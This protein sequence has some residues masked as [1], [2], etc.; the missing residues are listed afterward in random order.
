MLI[1][2]ERMMGFEPTTFSLAT[3]S[4]TT[5]LHPRIW[6]GIRESNP[7]N[8]L[9]RLEHYHYANPAFYNWLRGLD[10]NQRFPAYETSEDVLTPLP[11]DNKLF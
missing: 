4:S 6:S 8:Q 1:E 9:G 3:R 10:L 5:E 2:M 7:S 11:H